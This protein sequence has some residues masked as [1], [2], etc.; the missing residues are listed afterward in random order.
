MGRTLENVIVKN[1]VD[2][3]NTK[4]GLI[5]ASAIREVEVKA[6]VDT[7]AAMLCLPPD[8]IKNLGLAYIETKSVL[9]ANGKVERRVFGGA[10][11]TIRD[12]TIQMAVMENSDE[13]PSLI[14]YLVLESMDYVVNSNGEKLMPNPEHDGK[15]VIDLY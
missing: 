9:T 3:I 4:N 5:E 11:I 7:G 2:I 6:L 10:T 15:W 12:R 8:A 14:G 1:Y 13:T